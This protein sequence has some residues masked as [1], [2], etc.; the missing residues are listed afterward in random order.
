MFEEKDTRLSQ[1]QIIVMT[2]TCV[3]GV[4]VDPTSQKKNSYDCYLFL[5]FWMYAQVHKC[6]SLF[7]FIN[8][9]LL[10]MLE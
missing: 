10:K 8:T 9:N 3:K 6:K 4:L 2:C 5:Y 1:K 7:I